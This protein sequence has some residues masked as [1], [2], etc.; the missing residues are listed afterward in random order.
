MKTLEEFIQD[1]DLLFDVFNKNEQQRR[2][3]EKT[4]KL[5]MNDADWSF[6]HD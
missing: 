3:M 5:R 6:Y 4:Y 2:K 1:V